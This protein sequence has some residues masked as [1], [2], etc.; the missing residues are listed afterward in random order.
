[1]QILEKDSRR[2]EGFDMFEE[3]LH[4]EMRGLG[5]ISIWSVHTH[6]VGGIDIQWMQI[7]EEDPRR[8][9]GFGTFEETVYVEL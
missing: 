9:K 7:L 8:I 4:L 5:R 6:G 3:T 1:M 2:I